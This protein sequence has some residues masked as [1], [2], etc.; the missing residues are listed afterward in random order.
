MR[1]ERLLKCVVVV[2]QVEGFPDDTCCVGLTVQVDERTATTNERFSKKQVDSFLCGYVTV[3][4]HPCEQ[5]L[6]GTRGGLFHRQT[7]TKLV[8]RNVVRVRESLRF[9]RVLADV[10][11]RSFPVKNG[12][13]IN[14]SPPTE[15]DDSCVLVQPRVVTNSGKRFASAA[16][17][18][19][20]KG[21]SFTRQRVWKVKTAR[22]ISVTLGRI[23]TMRPTNDGTVGLTAVAQV[24]VVFTQIPVRAFFWFCKILKQAI[25]S[26]TR[27]SQFWIRRTQKLVKVTTE[28]VHGPRVRPINRID[29]DGVFKPQKAVDVAFNIEDMGK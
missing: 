11:S 2:I 18:A 25:S 8:Q 24:D 1:E 3:G 14:V 12:L 10:P 23:A 17:T 21:P 15:Q 19:F 9:A 20:D 5:A 7:C 29:F 28:S 13:H 27:P 6:N 22:A 4:S 16:S 26:R